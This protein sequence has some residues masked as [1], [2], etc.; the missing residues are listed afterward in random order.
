[1]E[2]QQPKTLGKQKSIACAKCEW[3][4]WTPIQ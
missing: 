3:V 4:P 1:V 2:Y